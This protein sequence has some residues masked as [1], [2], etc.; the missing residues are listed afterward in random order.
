MTLSRFLL[1]LP[2]EQANHHLIETKQHGPGARLGQTAL[3]DLQMGGDVQLLQQ[4]GTEHLAIGSEP[5]GS[6]HHRHG[7]SIVA[8]RHAQAYALHWGTRPLAR[9]CS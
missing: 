3:P 8:A 9:A 2:V 4:V 7:S 1:W 6:L 5:A